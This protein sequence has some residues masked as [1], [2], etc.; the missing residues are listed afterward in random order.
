IRRKVM[1][2]MADRHQDGANIM[3]PLTPEYEEK[4][5]ALQDEGLAWQVLVA[6]PTV[7]EV[8]SK[9][10]HRVDLEYQTCTRQ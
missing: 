9:R 4:L 10:T 1:T 8:F 5:A 6:S 3:T 2:M 7:F